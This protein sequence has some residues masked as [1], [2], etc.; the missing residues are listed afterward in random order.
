MSEN[1]LVSIIMPVYNASEFIVDSIKSVLAQDYQEFELLVVDDGS[2]DHS[3]DLVK[4]FSDPR[5]KVIQGQHKG[6]SAARNIGLAVMKGDFFCFLDADD[7]MT[8]KS[9]SSRME[10]LENNPELTIAGGTQI[11]KDH[12]L[13]QTLMIQEPDYEGNPKKGLITL[14]PGCFINC[15]TWLLKRDPE[16]KYQFMEGLTHAEDLAFFYSIAERSVLGYTKEPVQVYRRSDATAMKNLKGLEKG[17]R[18]YF[19]LVRASE[20]TGTQ[21][22][23]WRILKI[24]FLSYLAD[25]NFINAF[26]CI[27]RILLW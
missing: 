19:E 5:I 15:G 21:S 6:V 1:S 9:I 24:M 23:R 20:K 8:Q 4:S 25:S 13:K 3:M 7:L 26:T 27:F 17:Y 16:L 11:Q 14:D 12:S 2:T 22:L 10:V 18:A